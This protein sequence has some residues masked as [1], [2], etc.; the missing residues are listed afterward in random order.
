M[1]VSLKVEL[2]RI[3]IKGQFH[4]NAS[5]FPPL[6]RPVDLPIHLK[7]LLTVIIEK[8]LHCN[9]ESE[10]LPTEKMLMKIDPNINVFN[11]QKAG[12]CDSENLVFHIFSTQELVQRIPKKDK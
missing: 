9:K 4:F 2:G 8:K 10:N 12:N 5:G 6:I 3:H 11:S 1:L 7:R